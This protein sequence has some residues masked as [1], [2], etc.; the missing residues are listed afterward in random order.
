MNMSTHPS[1]HGFF[2]CVD[3]ESTP[4]WP[5]NSLWTHGCPHPY[6]TQLGM[7]FMEFNPTWSLQDKKECPL[8]ATIW[9]TPSD[10]RAPR[11]MKGSNDQSG[12]KKAA[13]TSK[14]QSNPASI[15]KWDD[16]ALPFS[17]PMKA[18]YMSLRKLDPTS[19]VQKV[20]A[21][22]VKLQMVKP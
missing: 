6:L 20:R 17:P 22:Q 5:W 8:F 14:L 3:Q 16:K 19:W 21:L 9:E 11:D 15:H 12:F 13:S 7:E 10:I 18:S 1:V 2:F 4:P